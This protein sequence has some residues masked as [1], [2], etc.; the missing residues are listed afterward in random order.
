M[1]YHIYLYKIYVNKCYLLK[2]W[3]PLALAPAQ[4]H[5][6]LLARHH[7]CRHF[8][9]EAPL[10]KCSVTKLVDHGHLPTS[11]RE[12]IIELRL[13]AAWTCC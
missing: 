1:I 7:T 5:S 12:E 3:T 10:G 13:Q 4:A 11:T 8:D 6:E 9:G 2:K